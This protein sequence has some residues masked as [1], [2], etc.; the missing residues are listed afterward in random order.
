MHLAGAKIERDAVERMD[1]RKA[2]VDLLEA[3]ER[4]GLGHRHCAV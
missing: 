2:L 1:A 3:K 4:F